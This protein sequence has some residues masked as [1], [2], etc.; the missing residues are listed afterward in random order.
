MDIFN[1]AKVAELEHKLVVM[2][3]ENERLRHMVDELTWIKGTIP[4]DCLPGQL[5][6]ACD[7]ARAFHYRDYYDDGYYDLVVRYVC[8]KGENCKHFIQKEV[9]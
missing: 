9:K 7:H 4:D 8:N 5:C 1:K 6:H 2:N 3:R